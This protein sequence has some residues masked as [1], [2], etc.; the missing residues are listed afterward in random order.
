MMSLLLQL[1][2][3][4]LDVPLFLFLLFPLSLLER[5]GGR[6]IIIFT[7]ELVRNSRGEMYE[8]SRQRDLP[9]RSQCV[10]VCVLYALKVWG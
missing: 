1:P 10:Y 3:K 9:E 6:T 8:R 7:Q 2:R 4:V 5:G